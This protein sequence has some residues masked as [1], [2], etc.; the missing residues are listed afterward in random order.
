MGGLRRQIGIIPRVFFI[1]GLFY[2]RWI[3]PVQRNIP[4]SGLQNVFPQPR[5]AYDSA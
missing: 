1:P 2:Q 4:G 5:D 3:N